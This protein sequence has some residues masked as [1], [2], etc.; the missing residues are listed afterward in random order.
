MQQLMEWPRARQNLPVC[1]W[2]MV[3]AFVASGSREAARGMAAM[4]S[5]LE[6]RFN[7]A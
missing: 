4:P 1:G 7:T 5:W 6:T 2:S 3:S